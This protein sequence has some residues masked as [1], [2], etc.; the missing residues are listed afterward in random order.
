MKREFDR[1]IVIK[2]SD[3]EAAL[4]VKRITQT[5]IEDL[6]ELLARIRVQRFVSNKEA[7]K[8]VVVE[9]DWPEYE[10]VWKAIEERVNGSES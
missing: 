7:L 9:S 1:Y 5:D 4:K 6:K 3:L 8:C 2:A 10:A